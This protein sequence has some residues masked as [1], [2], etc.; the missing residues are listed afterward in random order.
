MKPLDAIYGPKTAKV[1]ASILKELSKVEP[2]THEEIR[3]DAEWMHGLP[4]DPQEVWKALAVMV[5][6]PHIRQ[7]LKTYDPQALKQARRALGLG[8]Q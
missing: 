8:A 6:T 3:Q 4:Y 2:E 5:L 1:V 7:H